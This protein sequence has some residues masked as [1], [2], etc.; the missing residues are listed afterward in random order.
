MLAILFCMICLAA[1][2]AAMAQ[3][4]VPPD[5]ASPSASPPGGGVPTESLGASSDADMWRAVR[6][7]VEGQV[8][9]PDKQA[10]V[11]I[12]SDGEVWRVVRNGPVTFYGGMAVIGIVLL[13]AL[14]F[15]IRGRVRVEAGFAGV[16]ISRF[17]GLERFSHWLTAVSF[18]ILA[19]TGLNVMF[20]RYLL[21]PLIG[22]QAFADITLAGKFLHNYVAFAFMAGLVL[23]LVLWIK[24][25]FPN[26]YDLVWIGKAGGMLSRG[27]HPPA[28][29]F[30]AGQKVI[31]WLVVLG[32][33]SVS[34]SGIS[35][36]FPF[37]TA[38]FSKTFEAV[39]LLG[40]D[41]PAN[42][43][44]MQEMQLS[45]VWHGVVA[46]FLVIVI[47]AHIYIGTIGMEGAFDAMGSGRVDLNW[48]REHH[49][50]WV[51]ELERKGA[52]DPRPA[53]D[54]ETAEAA[55]PQTAS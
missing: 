42:L 26:R 54:G 27:T 1:P 35:L 13:L 21:K 2:G 22:A 55:K 23:V 40:F 38:F 20:G 29:K 15:L 53:E 7:G 30:N 44:A 46:L 24:D 43:T 28:K 6:Q 32:G 4:V 18:L 33:L 50:I 52:L 45:Q 41:L 39:N 49:S 11:L 47:I 48:A 10:G 31:F 3:A 12:Q 19:F 9:I 5:D 17:N 36:L 14:F 25:N 37:Q 16:T 51:E 34:L 8:S